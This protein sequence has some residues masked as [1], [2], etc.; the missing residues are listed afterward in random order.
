MTTVS[1]AATVT[2]TMTDD[3]TIQTEIVTTSYLDL[4]VDS[5]S[6][7]G[8]GVYG[9]DED[10]M[11]T[12]VPTTTTYERQ[13]CSS[14]TEAPNLIITDD[15]LLLLSEE[16]KET[17]R[18][19]CWETMFGQ[20]LTKLTVMDLVLTAVSTVIGDFLRAVIVR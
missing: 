12:F 3:N 17:L 13:F 14:S 10:E 20:E 7:S 4:D 18:T 8:T 5:G 6:G 15:D 9:A 1:S 16:Q 19:L 2:G 11:S